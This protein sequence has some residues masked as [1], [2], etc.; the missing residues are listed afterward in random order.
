MCEFYQINARP[1]HS[2]LKRVHI[3][4]EVTLKKSRKESFD[5]EMISIDLLVLISRFL[6]IKP[7]K[8][9]FLAQ[10]FSSGIFV[11]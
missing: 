10:T 6:R 8:Y 7:L 11:A 4:P 9:E 3:L 2:V 5:R 1:Q